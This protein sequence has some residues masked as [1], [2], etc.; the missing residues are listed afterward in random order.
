MTKQSDQL[1]RWVERPPLRSVQLENFKS[2][3]SE[4]VDLGMLTVLVGK[5]S[6]GKSTLLDA[7]LMR[8][9]AG[10]DMRNPGVP[11]SGHLL[12]LGTFDDVLNANC[13][14]D[15][16]VKVGATISV[17][18]DD[19]PESGPRGPRRSR[20]RT[21]GDQGSM[22]RS[23]RQNRFL[24]LA[25]EAFRT[26]A[27]TINEKGFFRRP[28]PYD[29]TIHWSIG[30]RSRDEVACCD[31]SLDSESVGPLASATVD[32]V[33]T[34][35]RQR[36]ALLQ[37]M[38]SM[39]QSIEYQRKHPPT[40]GEATHHAEQA[41]PI[42]EAVL[43]DNLPDAVRTARD[44]KQ[45]VIRALVDYWVELLEEGSTESE[46]DPENPLTPLRE[47]Q[48]ALSLG[49]PL[50]EHW[51]GPES[52]EESA[53]PSEELVQSLDDL[54]KQAALWVEFYLD[55]VDLVVGDDRLGDLVKMA[56]RHRLRSSSSEHHPQDFFEGFQILPMQNMGDAKRK[57][58]EIVGLLD[59]GGGPEG[60]ER[61]SEALS[62]RGRQG[63]EEELDLRV[64][65]VAWLG[66]LYELD[67]V[68]QFYDRVEAAMGRDDLGAAIITNQDF[69][70]ALSSLRRAV[71][72]FM[73]NHISHI[74]PLRQ[75][76][77]AVYPTDRDDRLPKVGQKGEHTAAVLYESRDRKVVC[78][79]KDGPPEELALSDAVAYWLGS[80]CLHL[81]DDIESKHSGAAGYELLVKPVGV[82][83]WVHLMAV[84]TGVSQV[85][86]VLVQGLLC[87]MGSVLVLQEPGSQL[88]PALQQNLGD[89]L[90]ACAKSGKQVLL[91]THSE[92]LVTRLA[93]RIAEGA[94][95]NLVKLLRV[96]YSEEAGTTYQPA[97]IDEY[98][99]I[100]WPEGF[101]EEASD[102]A[103]KILDAGLAK[104]ATQED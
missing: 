31:L 50:M 91:E 26:F 96:D 16:L 62:R 23:A 71:Q 61:L 77:Q 99:T 14:E 49:E 38:S 7:I 68:R 92:Y 22:S 20:R 32:S 21:R 82:D 44:A 46:V 5:N 27:R 41:E 100:E 53:S 98:G 9:Q 59:A 86:P 30:F 42:C 94:D 47:E 64:D 90:L 34:D 2:V 17:N 63:Y 88:H 25:E 10:I 8:S 6:A 12:N 85:L 81:V 45:L 52:H 13:N 66:I 76:P 101:F 65:L 43:V 58:A 78:P 79:K 72:E 83:K 60:A 28:K 97:P 87:D 102:E 67:G 18:F 84:G 75:P 57:K 51:S 39:G 56:P 24:L 104:Q 15:P 48:F 54:A 70:Y 1:G 33:D 37:H 3:F 95:A 89:F 40:F 74:G 73:V 4:D 55:H 69:N 103:F 80:E 19:E 36:P 11:L 35:G 29:L 93:R